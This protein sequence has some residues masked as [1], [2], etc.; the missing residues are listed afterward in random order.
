MDSTTAAPEAAS[1]PASPPIATNAILIAMLQ[2]SPNVSDLVFSPGKAA[3]VELN[4]KLTGVKIGDLSVLTAADT[5]LIAKDLMAGNRK[6]QE[7]LESQGACDL[8]YSIPGK[9][10]FRV[11]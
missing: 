11:N 4:G 2:I 5:L 9:S 10:R 3:Q 1:Q 7:Q 6:A 8:S